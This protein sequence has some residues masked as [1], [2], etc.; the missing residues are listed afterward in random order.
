[1]RDG[2]VCYIR[3]SPFVPLST[4]VLYP[5]LHD[6]LLPVFICLS[7]YTSQFSLSSNVACI[8]P[9]PVNPPNSYFKEDSKNKNTV[10][11]YST[12]A[13]EGAEI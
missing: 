6:I 5:L 1:M 8:F 9:R 13:S 4:N 3:H 12:N 7:Q 10:I 2:D 11:I